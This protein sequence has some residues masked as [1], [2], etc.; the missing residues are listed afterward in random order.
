[1]VYDGFISSGI[2]PEEWN[3]FEG[4]DKRF[5]LGGLFMF[6]VKGSKTTYRKN[7]KDI[8]VSFRFSGEDGIGFGYIL[9]DKESAERVRKFLKLCCRDVGGSMPKN[10]TMFET[11]ELP[12]DTWKEEYETLVGLSV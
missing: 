12:I 8:A 6:W 5:D 4:L 10:T 9:G 1:M 7:G 11:P 3:F 2:E